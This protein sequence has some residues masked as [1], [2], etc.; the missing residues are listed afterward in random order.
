MSKIKT[1]SLSTGLAM[2]SMF[3]G[4]GNITFPLMI[5]QTVEKGLFFALIGL[6]LTAVFIPFSGL[7]SITLFK[8]DYR[9]FFNR[10]GRAPGLFV[11]IVLLSIIG[12]FGGIPRCVTLTFST[13]KIYFSSLELLPFSLFS[14]LLI[15]L[16][17][18]RRNRILD[19]IGYVLSPLLVLFL[20][21]IIIKGIFFSPPA[22][23]VGAAIDHPFLYG[24][25][26]GY[27][28]MDLIAAFF[29]SSLVYQRLRVQMAEKKGSKNLLLPIFKASLI[30]ASLLSFIYIGFSHVAANYS[31]ELVGIP[32]DQLLGKIGHVILG[33]Q[34]G[35]VVSMSIALTCLTTAI[36][37]TVVCA[38]FLQKEIFKEKFRYEVS[39]SCILITTALISCLE[40]NGIVKML[41]PVLELI[42]PSLLVLSV[43]NILHKLYDIKPVKVPVFT[44]VLLV[45]YFQH[46]A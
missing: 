21:V 33:P 20:S 6:V 26:E 18:W 3:F 17:C 40:F 4:A 41:A 35:L 7:L 9:A 1:T 10:M 36:A 39:L 25:K 38:E 11:I 45:L 12:P 46:V 43:F 23:S 2:F 42:Y 5:G 15:F 8:G 19:I 32:M 30:G 37:L 14:C 27:N 29:F 22:E 13:L 31:A 24:L 28:T 44:A 34:A 16:F